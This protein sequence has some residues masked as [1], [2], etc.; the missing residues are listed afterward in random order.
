MRPARSVP[1]KL[2]EPAAANKGAAGVD[3]VSVERFAKDKDANLRRLSAIM[4]SAPAAA[5]AKAASQ[6]AAMVQ[7]QQHPTLV[8]RTLLLTAGRSFPVA[9]PRGHAAPWRA[10]LP[11]W[12]SCRPSLRDRRTASSTQGL[13]VERRWP[14]PKRKILIYV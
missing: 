13:R 9:T 3:H 4:L 8:L 2:A 7:E 6:A 14:F 12:A 5:L 11:A 10:G 1:V